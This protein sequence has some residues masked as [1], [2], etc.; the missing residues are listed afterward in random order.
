MYDWTEGLNAGS[1]GASV[2]AALLRKRSGTREVIDVQ[3][4]AEFQAKGIDLL[5]RHGDAGS[6][7]YETRI[8][9]KWDKYPHTGNLAFETLSIVAA[10]TPGCFLTSTADEWWYGFPALGKFYVLPLARTRTWFLAEGAHYPRK[11]T[12]TRKGEVRWQTEFSPVPIPD[13]LAAVSGIEV[14]SFPPIPDPR[15]SP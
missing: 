6:S 14:V 4:D 7:T 1:S 11:V 15:R 2:V 12:S 3:E 13:V 10:N 5:W 8:E 9:V